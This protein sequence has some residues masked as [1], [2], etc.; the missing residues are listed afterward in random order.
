[1]IKIT[2][3]KDLKEFVKYLH[4]L[5]R[6]VKMAA[7]KAFAFY[8]IGN[9]QHGLK[10]EPTWK[11]VSRAQAYGKVSDAP[12]G[13]FSWKQFRYVAKIT[14]GFTKIPYN[15]AHNMSGS[16]TFNARDNNWTMVSVT[17]D[18]PGVDYVMGDKQSRHEALV[19]WR[20]WRVVI[21]SNFAG[22]MREAR[23]AIAP[24]LRKGK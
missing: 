4:E 19:G 21:A 13:Y 8:L 22:A 16:W 10:H 20:K 7:M 3:R 6:G 5:P 9:E 1:M 2:P 12:P 23:R 15:R 11:F 17:N 24:L 14:D 18:V